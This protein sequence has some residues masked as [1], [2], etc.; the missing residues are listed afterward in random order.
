MSKLMTLNML[1]EALRDGRVTL[2]TRFFTDMG[3]ASLDLVMLGTAV[4]EHYGRR[5]PFVQFF[6]ELGERG[7]ADIPVRR[8]VD[9]IHAQLQ[10]DAGDA[11]AAPSPDLGG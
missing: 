5:F 10:A 3:L 6:A 8:W 7:E 1:F 4:Q 9:F 11:T 2:D